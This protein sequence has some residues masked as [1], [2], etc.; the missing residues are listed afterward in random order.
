MWN[1]FFECSLCMLHPFWSFNVTTAGY[2]NDGNITELTTLTQGYEN[3][4]S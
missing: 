4:T 3:C 1:L 2:L